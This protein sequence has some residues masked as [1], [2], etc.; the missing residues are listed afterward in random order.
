MAVYFTF[1]LVTLLLTCNIAW[2]LRRNAVGLM[3]GMSMGFFYFILL[4]LGASLISGHPLSGLG[5]GVWIGDTFPLSM[6]YET[7]MVLACV[8]SVGLLDTLLLL[9][10]VPHEDAR[11][12]MQIETSRSLIISKFSV[13][14]ALTMSVT[15]LIVGFVANGLASGGHWAEASEAFMQ[16]MGVAAQ[17]LYLARA[18]AQIAALLAILMAL[19]QKTISLKFAGLCLVILAVFQL[20]TT[21]N[22]VFVLYAAFGITICLW[23]Q[24]RYL[25]LVFIFLAAI[26]FGS[27]M[28]LFSIIRAYMHSGRGLFFGIT[29]G[30]NAALAYSFQHNVIVQFI[31]GI[32]ESSDV[33]VAIH[34]VRDFPEHHNLLYG[35]TLLK[36]LV[37]WIPRSLWPGKP[38]SAPA[39]L[40]QMYA[41][42]VQGLSLAGTLVGEMYI[43][44][45][46]LSIL[47]LPLLTCIVGWCIWKSI[48]DPTLRAL[49]GFLF[50]I[51]TMR[52]N[53][54]D[55]V[56]NFVGGVALFYLIYRLQLRRTAKDSDEFPVYAEQWDQS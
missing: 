16:D 56:L 50:A 40:A 39:Y 26:P 36:S 33:S 54:S 18:A 14:F 31:Y 24:R 12:S 2:R 41:P 23:T 34:A 28:T 20:F 22:R 21:G 32:T 25:T 11:R 44:F 29:K 10:R 53:A 42:S 45:A 38:E 46:W 4:P 5:A 43:N 6:A 35:A 1:I 47:I 19:L 13:L 48:R 8:G 15:L 17:L 37:F 52:G 9:M 27:F 49:V 51:A 7:C 30:W 55:M 3:L